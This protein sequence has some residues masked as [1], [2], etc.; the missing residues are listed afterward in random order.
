MKSND[1]T[2]YNNVVY[3]KKFCRP[4]TSVIEQLREVFGY[5]TNTAIYDAIKREENRRNIDRMEE[6]AVKGRMRFIGGKAVVQIDLGSYMIVIDDLSAN[7]AV[8]VKEGSVLETSEYKAGATV[9]SVIREI[10]KR[11]EE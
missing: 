7:K 1:E 4:L 6:L 2:I 9:E 3:A 8:I 5:K 11:M 10:R